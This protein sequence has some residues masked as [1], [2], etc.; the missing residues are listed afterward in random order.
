MKTITEQLTTYASYHRDRRNIATHF[1][2]IPMIT[3]GVAVLLSRPGW[4]LL[5]PATIVALG[6]SLYYLRLEA[7]FGALMTVLMAGN[8]AIGLTVAQQSTAVWLATGL[9]LFIVGWVIQ[10]IG[11]AYEGKKPA[12]VDDLV[13][14]LLGPLFITAEVVFALGLRREMLAAIEASVGPTVVR[15]AEMRAALRTST[16]G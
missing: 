13:G 6:A 5:T 3:I 12:F 4:G 15:T 7:R 16:T 8:L 10:F 11:H 2:G 9:T 1:F 14:L